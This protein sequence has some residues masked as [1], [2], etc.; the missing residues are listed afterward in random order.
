MVRFGRYYGQEL[1]M[2]VE[3]ISP[4]ENGWRAVCFSCSTNLADVLSMRFQEAE[5]IF[6]QE[7]GLRIPRQ[8]LRV[9]EDGSVFVYVQ[10][11]L[12]EEAKAVELITDHGD[13]YV[14]RGEG[15]HAGDEIIV[16][17][18]GLYDGKVVAD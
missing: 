8:A 16:S 13:Y 7:T 9:G 18:K 12:R 4:E 5:L 14:V 11:G 6:S 1:K 2:T 10:T 3:S 17:G 15:L